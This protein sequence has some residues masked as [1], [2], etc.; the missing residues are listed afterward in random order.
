MYFSKTTRIFITVCLVL[1]SAG[2]C[3]G[4]FSIAQTQQTCTPTITATPYESKYIDRI[5]L[6][7]DATQFVFVQDEGNRYTF[8]FTFTAEK[9]QP[10]FYAVLDGFDLIGI[11]YQEISV[12]AATQN[13]DT[14]AIPGAEL[15]ASADGTT[16]ALQW[17][18][19]VTIQTDT[20]V[21]YRPTLRISYTSGTKYSL[22]QSYQ[23]EAELLVKVCNLDPLP[24]VM[25]DARVYFDLGI[26]TEESL[27]QLRDKL[28]EIEIA[29]RQPENLTETQISAW[30][31]EIAFCISDLQPI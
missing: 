13:G 31:E 12:R 25:E 4:A 18:V 20:P 7:L 6:Q 3:L 29:L 11:P 15:P 14:V 9:E 19:F 10:D 17:T 5:H 30:L 22:A 28:D 26:Y 8:S 16:K 23:L 27:A 21:T 2:L 24:H 1:L